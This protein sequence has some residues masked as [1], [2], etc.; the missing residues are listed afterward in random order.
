[1][2][3]YEKKENTDEEI[4]ASLHPLVAEWFKK[5]FGKFS[6]PQRAAVLNIH[7]RENVRI[8]APTGSGKTLSG[9]LAILNELIY[10]SEKG[11]LEDKVYCIYISPFQ[12][13]SLAP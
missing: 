7:N 2:I 8:S 12:R 13:S 4:Y 11:E 9:F 6:P 1:M 5:K 10:A 3:T